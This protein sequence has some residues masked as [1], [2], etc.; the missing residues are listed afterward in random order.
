MHVQRDGLHISSRV[1]DWCSTLGREAAGPNRS[2]LDVIAVP[3]M[4]HCVWFL[5]IRGG[6]TYFRALAP[7]MGLPVTVLLAAV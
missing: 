2:H 7:P 5:I 1:G 3:V 4:N 6:M